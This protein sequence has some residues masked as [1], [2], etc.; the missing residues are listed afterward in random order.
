[1]QCIG[2]VA[3]ILSASPALA[4]GENKVVNEKPKA[5]IIKVEKVILQEKKVEEL[6]VMKPKANSDL[7]V[8]KNNP[9]G[10]HRNNLL[11]DADILGE[12]LL[13]IEE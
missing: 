13:G 11:L 6:M 12:G 7:A 5:E 9:L 1:V 10:I 8:H 4:F 2:G 3:L